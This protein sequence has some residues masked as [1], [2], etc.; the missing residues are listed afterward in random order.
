LN[1][2]IEKT[3]ES[4]LTVNGKVRL[5]ESKKTLKKVRYKV[6]P[7]YD[8]RKNFPVKLI[9]I[10]AAD[11]SVKA[12][13]RSRIITVNTTTT[14]KEAN[15]IKGNESQRSVIDILKFYRQMKPTK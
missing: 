7:Y 13:N 5:I 12:V 10:N 3:I 11:D 4:R 8:T 2:K 9:T 14:I 6:S 15:S 1:P